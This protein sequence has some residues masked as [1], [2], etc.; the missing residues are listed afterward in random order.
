MASP[1][2]QQQICARIQRKV[3]ELLAHEIKDPRASFVTITEVQI[4]SD[5]AVATVK[6]TVL[7]DKDR[8]KVEHMFGHANKFIRRAVARDIN[9]RSA[10]LLKFEFDLGLEHANKINKIL[11]DLKSDNSDS[12]D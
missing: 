9:I 1:R 8:S 6:W 3:A 5:L 11:S 10:P 2:R 7:N 4:S 12:N